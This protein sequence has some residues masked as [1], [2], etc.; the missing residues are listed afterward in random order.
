MQQAMIG[1]DLFSGIG[2][3]SLA[4]KDIIQPILYCEIDKFCQQVLLNRMNKNELHKAEIWGDVRTLKSDGLRTRVD[5]VYGGFPCQDISISRRG[6]GL[7]GERSI[8]FFEI[9]RIAKASESPFIFVENVAAVRSRGLTT[10]IKA[11]TESGY[12]CRYGYLSAYDVGAPH[13]RERWFCLAYSSTFG[14]NRR[15]AQPTI[16]TKSNVEKNAFAITRSSYFDF[17]NSWQ[18]EPCLGRVA[19]GVPNRVDRIKG[20]GNAVVPLQVRT[21]FLN[22]L[23][24]SKC[25]DK[26]N[27]RT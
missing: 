6:Q 26:N 22:L 14:R 15:G 19:D 24:P 25:L 3:I 12:D 1:I 27:V 11:L 4:L 13:K 20:L 21:A 10:I 2:G 9:L 23:Y 18:V 8:L 16:N 7:E 17:S 5:I